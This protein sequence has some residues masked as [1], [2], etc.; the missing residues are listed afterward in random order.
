[1]VDSDVVRCRVVRLWRARWIVVQKRQM[2]RSKIAMGD[3]FLSDGIVYQH[4]H[5]PDRAQ[6]WAAKTPLM[7]IERDRV[8]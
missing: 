1:V 7:L 8:T 6:Q 2:R 5:L 4:D 3:V